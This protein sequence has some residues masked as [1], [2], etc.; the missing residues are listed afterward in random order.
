[1]SSTK[2]CCDICTKLYTRKESLYRH[3]LLCEY[4]TKSKREREII[5]EEA[6]DTPSYNDLVNIV[7][8]LS[9]KVIKMEEQLAE[10]QQLTFKRKK[11][12]VITYINQHLKPT[13][14]YYE[15]AAKQSN[16]LML[17][18]EHIENLMESNLQE[19]VDKV[20]EF[21]FS[22]RKNFVYPIVAVKGDIY[23]CNKED[24]CWFWKKMNNE[25]FGQFLGV[26]HNNLITELNKWR[27]KHSAEVK[28]NDKISIR[29]NKTVSKLMD[30][31]FHPDARFNKMKS[32]LVQ[33]ITM[34]ISSIEL[35]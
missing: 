20:F 33:F 31:S 7:H 10:I 24:E 29:F 13:V 30:M 27:E 9:Q 18:L 26:I 35:N 22:G 32:S 19:T 1:M 2:F 34:E 14:T 4:K 6:G 8:Q 17:E 11:I 28:N 16:Y 5:V 21:L 23:I 12:D 3:K 15:W 25:E